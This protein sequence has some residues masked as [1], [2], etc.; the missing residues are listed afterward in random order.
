MS[1][2]AEIEA[3]V[4]G[5]APPQQEAL[6]KFLLQRLD[7]A[8]HGQSK[9]RRGLKSASRPALEGLP[10]DLSI[11]TKNRV[12]SLVIQRQGADR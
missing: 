12:R 4:D 1:T 8:G 2:L 3:A 11:G 7:R 10:K 6:F 5:L 9:A